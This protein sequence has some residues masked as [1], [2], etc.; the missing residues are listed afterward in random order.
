MAIFEKRLLVIHTP[1]TRIFSLV[2]ETSLSIGLNEG[3]YKHTH[4][5]RLIVRC[6]QKV[7]EHI[8]L[9]GAVSNDSQNYMGIARPLL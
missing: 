3:L 4:M 5:D 1:D 6:R 8:E 7:E 9:V 2:T